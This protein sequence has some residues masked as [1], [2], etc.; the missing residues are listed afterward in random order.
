MLHASKH[1]LPFII[2]WKVPSGV[3]NANPEWKS[4]TAIACFDDTGKSALVDCR[5]LS[6]AAPGLPGKTD[7]D[8][9][10]HAL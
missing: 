6:F 7:P 8:T 9:D 5:Y 10:A 4:F 2:V 1:V 3:R